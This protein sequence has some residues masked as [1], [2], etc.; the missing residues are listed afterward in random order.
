REQTAP[1]QRALFGLGCAGIRCTPGG[2]SAMILV[3]GAG[4]AGLT[5]AKVLVEAGKEVRILEAS[6]RI[7]GRVRTDASA[8]GFLLDRGF[9]VLFTAYPAAQ[10]HLDIKALKPHAF[11]PGAVLVKGGQ[12]HELGDPLRKFSLLAPDLANPLLTFG[13]K[14]RTLRLAGYARRRKE[15]DIF[16][17]KLRGKVSDRSAHDELTRRHFTEAGFIANFARPLFG[18]IFLDR[19]LATSARA[20]AFVYKMLASGKIVLPE[21]GI[22]A[23]AA[24]LAAVLP[25]DAIW[26]ENRVE[27]IVGAE[28]HAVGVTLTGGEEMQADAIV[29]ATDAPSAQRLLGH[30]LPS[31]AAAATCVYF[32]S[33]QRLY[34]GPKLVLNCNPDAFVNHAVQISNISPA[35]APRGQHLLACTILGVPEMSD[36]ELTKRC[37]EDLATLFPGRDLAGLRHIATYR[38]RFAQFRQPPGSFT[39]LLTNVTPTAGLFLAGEYTESSSINGAMLS[40][41]KAAQAVLA[42]LA[43]EQ[44]SSADE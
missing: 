32:A 2:G 42:A 1:R 41:E 20:F 3:V 33:T 12:R 11:T 38:I 40:G 30:E 6:D 16:S 39:N 37:R 9:Q 18:G 7:G 44:A 10:R 36:A 13:D 15:R 35:Y 4:L 22:G 25:E 23:I 8:D 21:Q 14:L 29:I 31:E 43:A 17:G 26:L 27:G 5:C 24:Q 28:G 34:A 19:E